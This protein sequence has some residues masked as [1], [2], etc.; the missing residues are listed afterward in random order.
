MGSV[1]SSALSALR[2]LV[3]AQL[4]K[5]TVRQLMASFPQLRDM[6]AEEREDT[7][8]WLMHDPAPDYDTLSQGPAPRG[9]RHGPCGHFHWRRWSQSQATFE[10]KEDDTEISDEEDETEIWKDRPARMDV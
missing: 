9:V 5:A 6:P 1:L 8:R 4:G 2:N 3:N 7:L 10:A